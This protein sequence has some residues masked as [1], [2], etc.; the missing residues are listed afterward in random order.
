MSIHVECRDGRSSWQLDGFHVSRDDGGQQSRAR[1][2]RKGL[3]IQIDMVA[4]TLDVDA[5]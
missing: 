1:A 3:K 5:V 4:A 2:V